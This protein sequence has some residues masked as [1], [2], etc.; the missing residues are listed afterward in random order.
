MSEKTVITIDSGLI[1]SENEE[2]IFENQHIRLEAGIECKGT[3]ILKNCT[4]TWSYNNR[5]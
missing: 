4:I 2:K 3:L 1:V 5:K